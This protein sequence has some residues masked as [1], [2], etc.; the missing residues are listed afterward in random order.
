MRSFW[1]GDGGKLG[2]LA[3]RFAG[4]SDLFRHDGRKPTAGINFPTSH[5]GFTLWDLV[6]YNERHNEANLEGNRDGHGHNLSWNCGVEGA[7]DDSAVL[8]LRKRQMRNFLATLF[9]SQGVPMLLAGDEFARSQRGN[10]NAYCQDNEISWVD[11]RLRGV[12]HDLL[13]FVQLLAQLRQR[14]PQFRRETF[15]KGTARRAGMRDVTWLNALGAEM[16][17][18]DWQ[19]S[20]RRAMG[21]WYGEEA[22]SDGRLLLLLNAGDLSETFTLP[23]SVEAPWIRLLD[24]SFADLTARSLGTKREYALAARSV[25]LLEC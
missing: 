13:E 20:G 23:A 12:H 16:G 5:D 15:L 10:N 2:E 1:R 22:G 14:Y 7:S 19:D 21:V 8:G 25:A 4:S 3:E 11:W 17:Q 6:S 9:F 24:T 18:G